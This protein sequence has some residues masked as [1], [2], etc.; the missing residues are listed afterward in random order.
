MNLIKILTVF[1]HDDDETDVNLIDV[2][3]VREESDFTTVT[4]SFRS[5]GLFDSIDVKKERERKRKRE[6]DQIRLSKRFRRV[7]RRD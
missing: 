6:I 7:S 4:S 3:T 5:A 2:I 1:T